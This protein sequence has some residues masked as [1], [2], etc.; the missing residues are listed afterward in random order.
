MNKILKNQENFLK[1]K[2]LR[3]SWI[4]I[5]TIKNLTEENLKYARTFVPYLK[6]RKNSYGEL[7]GLYHTCY[8]IINLVNSKCYFGKH[9]FCYDPSKYRVSQYKGS[10]FD[11]QGK[12][13]LENSMLK[14]G[15]ENFRMLVLKYFK[16]DEE[17]YAYE[18]KLITKE[19]VNS[20]HCYNLQGGGKGF[21]SGYLNPNYLIGKDG[22]T[23]PQR[24]AHKRSKERDLP[25]QRIGSDGL[26]CNQ[27]RVKAGNH[28]FLKRPDGTSG[29]KDRVNLGIHH[30]L[31]R[32]DGSS[33]SSDR[34]KKG[35]HNFLGIKPWENCAATERSLA[36][37]K[38]ANKVLKLHLVNPSFKRTAL[39]KL[40]DKKLQ[41]NLSID[42]IGKMLVKFKEGWLPN[43][44]TRWT[45]WVA[46]TRATTNLVSY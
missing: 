32:K 26:T 38:L 2:H 39:K 1:I 45:T 10:N 25:S 20:K 21:S 37:W 6:T 44:D 46:C 8:C 31:K 30:T 5:T 15:L 35:T 24:T 41:K 9:S 29:V 7:N 14:Y 27:R 28:N 3:K 16:T 19:M 18:T 42:S 36:T 23:S 43:E 13:H 34:V 12:K 22:F 4:K 11:I 33:I 40:L 17:A